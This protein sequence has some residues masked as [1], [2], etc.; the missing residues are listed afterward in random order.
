MKI[1]FEQIK[2]TSNL[3]TLNDIIAMFDTNNMQ[4]FYKIRNT[5]KNI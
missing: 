1:V 2:D 5:Y 3:D 4:E